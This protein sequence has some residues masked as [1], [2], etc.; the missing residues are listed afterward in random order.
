M[1]SFRDRTLSALTAASSSSPTVI[2][3]HQ[4]TLGLHGGLWPYSLR[5]I[6]KEGLCPSSGDINRLML[7]IAFY[8]N[9]YIPLTLKGVE[10]A[11]QMFFRDAYIYQ[12]YLAVRITDKQVAR[13]LVYLRYKC[14]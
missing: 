14:Y 3:T 13:R 9:T 6:Y 10:E 11:S 2:R 12:N 7:M 5:I 1:L 4:S 8:I